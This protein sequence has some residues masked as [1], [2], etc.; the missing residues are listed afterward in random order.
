MDAAVGNPREVAR[1]AKAQRVLRRVKWR[2]P[3]MTAEVRVEREQL[4]DSAAFVVRELGQRFSGIERFAF[5]L[6][7]VLFRSVVPKSVC[8]GSTTVRRF[9]N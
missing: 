3:W 7:T 5:R 2:R 4:I 6:G 9:A 1:V 8:L